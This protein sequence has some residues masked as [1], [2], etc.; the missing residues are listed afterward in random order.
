MTNTTMERLTR[1]CAKR[2]DSILTAIG[3]PD[4]IPVA[5][6]AKSYRRW[7]T[8]R[9]E[10]RL[11]ADYP[12]NRD[13]IVFDVGGYRGDWA[14]EIHSKF[15]STVHVFEPIAS[16]CAEIAARFSDVTNVHAHQFGLAAADGSMSLGILDDSTSQFKS[17]AES[18]VCQ[19][20]SISDFMDEHAIERV[21]LLKLNI[22]GGEYELLEHLLDT[23]RI[24]CFENIQVQFHW[25][26][27]DARRRM[28]AIQQRLGQTHAATYQYPFVW[29]NWT[30]EAA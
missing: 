28:A 1:S 14:D 22:E 13:D 4:R 26:V 23:G 10:E 11:R 8:E 15:G 30:S 16:Y 6:H 3:F 19:L 9:G 2:A 20:K 27:P 25:F 7:V 12:L 17:A 24:D 21:A 18:E 29:E 5:T